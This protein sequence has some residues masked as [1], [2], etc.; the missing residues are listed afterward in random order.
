[1]SICRPN[2]LLRRRNLRW[3]HQAMIGLCVGQLQGIHGRH[4]T[5]HPLEPCESRE[6]PRYLT[7]SHSSVI[8]L[9][10]ASRVFLPQSDSVTRTCS[11]QVAPREDAQRILLLNQIFTV[12]DNLAFFPPAIVIQ[13]V[14]GYCI[15]FSWLSETS[16]KPVPPL[17]PAM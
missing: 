1:M 9:P 7:L 16:P 15:T 17:F 2:V 3:Q 8:L 10:F 4:L 13:T 6:H 11:R 12:P 14:L 5:S